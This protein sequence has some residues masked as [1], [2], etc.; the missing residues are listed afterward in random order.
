MKPQHQHCAEYNIAA[1]VRHFTNSVI[2]VI[3]IGCLIGTVRSQQQF[4]IAVGNSDAGGDVIKREYYEYSPPGA[5]RYHQRQASPFGGILPGFIIV[6]ASSMMQWYNEGRA[7]RDAKMLAKA[8]QQVVELDSL[9]PIDPDNDGK[10]V[11]VSGHITTN[12]GLVDPEHG[13]Y[14]PGALQL[15]RATEAYEWKEQKSESRRR[16]SETETKVEVYYRY[17]K[18]WTQKHTDSN[19]FQSPNRYNPYPKYTLGRSVMTVSDAQMSNGLRVPPNLV[20]QI[21]SNNPLS[22][23]DMT[24]EHRHIA[25]SVNLL[26]VEDIAGNN[27]AVILSNENKLYISK[28]KSLSELLALGLS[29]PGAVQKSNIPIVR[30]LPYPEVGDIKVSWKEVTAPKEGV[31]IMAKQ[32]DGK[33]VPWSHDSNGH[34]VYSLIPGKYSAKAIISHL[35]GRSKFITKALRIG[36]WIGNFIGLSLVLSCIPALVKLLPFGIGHLLEPLVSIATSTVALGAS[37]GLSFSVIS[38]AWLRFRPWF[39]AG[40]AIVSGAGFLG[41]FY[42]ARWKRSPEV[43]ELDVRLKADEQ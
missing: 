17:N 21:A 41:P 2:L 23:S 6:V 22:I 31:S 34:T 33:L 12:N 43:V 3:F 38:V 11:H 7:V 5:D 30:S 25:S 29:Q 42:Y 39:A 16:V 35:I 24:A 19:R 4:G 27:D 15:I 13:L 37:T 28:N 26:N 18:Q 8:E 9:A 20:N 32:Q 40:L 10:L 36:G 1:M 14:R